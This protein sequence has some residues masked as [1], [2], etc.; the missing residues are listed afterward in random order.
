MVSMVLVPSTSH[1]GPEYPVPS[2]P[3][4]TIPACFPFRARLNHW[5]SGVFEGLAQ[6]RWFL[7]S[8]QLLGR[9][10]GWTLHVG[11]RSTVTAGNRS[12]CH[13][14]TEDHSIV[15][16]M[17][18]S[19]AYNQDCCLPWIWT[20]SRDVLD[21][22]KRSANDDIL[23]SWDASKQMSRDSRLPCSDWAIC[24]WNIRYDNQ[25]AQT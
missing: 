19:I 17:P 8:T 4:I 20:S 18:C 25:N 24:R 5:C 7:E 22:P 14:N 1:P 6:R 16:I 2:G 3:L 21:E 23:V 13:A 10:Q 9:M 15:D 12:P 11:D